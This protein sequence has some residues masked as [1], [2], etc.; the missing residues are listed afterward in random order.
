MEAAGHPYRKSGKSKLKSWTDYRPAGSWSL[1]GF[2]PITLKSGQKL[3]V[4][5]AP[6]ADS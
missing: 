4:Y 5:S 1:T 2:Q 6:G 3:A